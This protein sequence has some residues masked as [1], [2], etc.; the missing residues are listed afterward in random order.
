MSD[1]NRSQSKLQEMVIRGKEYREDYDFEM[2]GEEVTG[3]IRPL[4]DEEFLPLAAFL[5]D[6]FDVDTD[7]LDEEELAERA[8]EEIEEARDEEGDVDMSKLD[9]EFVATL[10]QAA[11]LGLEGAY[12]DNGEY[13]DHTKD[14]VKEMVTAMVGGYSVE[15]GGEVLDL[16]GNIRDAERF[17]GSWGR[18]HGSSVSQ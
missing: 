3:V 18:Q 8:N 4:P 2:F 7:E 5:A 15:L 13:V 11:I 12:D 9:K 14:E 1:N 17:R 16:S 10:Q 6:H